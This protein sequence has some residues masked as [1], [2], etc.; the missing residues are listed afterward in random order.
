MRKL[1]LDRI[2]EISDGEKKFPK[3]VMR[4]RNFSINNVHLSEVVFDNL[5]DEDLLITFERI[6]RF[7][8]K[9]M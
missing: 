2:Q 8:N 1:I 6:V 9:Q 7:L 5:S 4:W 3:S